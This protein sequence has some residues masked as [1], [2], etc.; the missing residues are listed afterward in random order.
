M[1]HGASARSANALVG[2]ASRDVAMQTG[3]QLS[4]DSDQKAQRRGQFADLGCPVT[5]M[6]AHIEARK[7]VVTDFQPLSMEIE[8]APSSVASVEA[9]VAHVE[10]SRQP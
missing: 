4:S 10:R 7:V 6:L 5:P 3:G 2:G 8:V 9:P 1:W